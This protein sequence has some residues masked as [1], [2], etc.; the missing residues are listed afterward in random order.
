[1]GKKIKKK[2]NEVVHSRV[3]ECT[4]HQPNAFTLQGSHCCYPI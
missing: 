1:M 3:G 4:F 2:K